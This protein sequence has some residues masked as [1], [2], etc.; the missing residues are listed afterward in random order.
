MQKRI[1]LATLAYLM[2]LIFMVAVPIGIADTEATGTSDGTAVVGSTDPTITNLDVCTSDG[3]T[4]KN[5]TAIDPQ[6]TYITNCT[7]IDQNTIA[8]IKNVTWVIFEETDADWGSADDAANHYTFLFDQDTNVWSE[9]GPGS[10]DEHIVTGSCIS[11]TDNSSSTGVPTLA[12]KLN[13]TAVYTGASYTWEINVTTYDA[14]EGS[15]TE[16][17]LFFGENFYSELTVTDSTHGWTGL[18]AGDTNV[19]M[20]D[21]DGDLNIS[22]TANANFNVQAQANHTHLIVYGDSSKNFT[23]GHILIHES[24]VGSAANLTSTG[25][26]DIGGLTDEAWG[27]NQD[28]A[29][30]LW[31]NIPATQATG[32]YV[33]QLQLKIV[34]Y[35]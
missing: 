20:T 1:I 18:D 6:T 14:A 16:T 15:D 13:E 34:R 10:S 19:T 27:A 3:V 2:M 24:T 21:P 25:Y 29:M 17:Q 12:F 33:Y 11:P 35:T 7:L 5:D 8:D 9:V 31:I 28:K 32:S 23:I 30:V 22:V 4:S 26:V